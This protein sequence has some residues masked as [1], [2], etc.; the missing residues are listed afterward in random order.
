MV[1]PTMSRAWPWAA[2]E[3][4]RRLVDT[5][6]D[7][8]R[9]LLEYQQEV[10][11]TLYHYTTTVGM[12]GI[13]GTQRL[14]VTHAGFLNDSTELLHAYSVVEYALREEENSTDSEGVKTLCMRARSVIDPFGG[15]QELFV[16]CFCT[17]SDL[18]SQWRAYGPGGDGFAL[19]FDTGALQT[20]GGID[21]DIVL[22]RVI[23]NPD[24]QLTMARKLVS[25][26]A[27]SVKESVSRS[28]EEG[29]DGDIGLH[30]QFLA[31]YAAEFLFTFKHPAFQEEDEWRLVVPV[32]SPWYFEAHVKHRA[33][34]GFTIPY[35]E[36]PLTREGAG[37][38]TASPISQIVVGPRTD[39]TLVQRSLALLQ[40][41]YGWVRDGVRM[42]ETPLRS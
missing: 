5:A 19:G 39:A 14:W 7:L 12:V 40:K 11:Q 27:K 17:K 24:L 10:P 25:S 38:L 36:L 33:G 3:A 2:T 41:S 35:L 23:Y 18:L 13:L 1:R 37:G 4:G 32:N 20:V 22:R 34:R 31:D 16:A 28:K 30:C 26:V 15:P 21:T 6:R 29:G 9:Q 42:S 8:D